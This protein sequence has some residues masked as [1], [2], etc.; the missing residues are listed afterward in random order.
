MFIPAEAVFAEIQAHHVDLVDKAHAARVWMVSPTTLW[1]TLNTA[2]AV[3]KDAA[4]KEQVQ[5]MI[6]SL[7][8]LDG[9][10]AADAAAHGRHERAQA[11]EGVEIDKREPNLVAERHRLGH[12]PPTDTGPPRLVGCNEPAQM[13]FVGIGLGAVNGDRGKEMTAAPGR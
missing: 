6:V 8:Q 10:P 4:T 9:A 13:G 2:R 7:L 11:L 12:E 3:L 5:H 1:A